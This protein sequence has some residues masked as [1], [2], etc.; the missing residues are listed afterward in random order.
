MELPL[1]AETGNEIKPLRPADYRFKIRFVCRNDTC[2]GHEFSVLDWELDALY[3]KMR[4]G[5]MGAGAAAGKV[6]EKLKDACGSDKDLYFFLGN[7]AS[8]PTTFTI[9]G[10]WY[11]RSQPQLS[12]R[13]QLDF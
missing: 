10:L 2:G 5:G 8:H 13:R 9:V 6:V 7:I 12:L 11:P 4:R 3:S 1:D